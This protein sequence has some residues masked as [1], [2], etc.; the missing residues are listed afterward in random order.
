ME[1]ASFSWRVQGEWENDLIRGLL[2]TT[3]AHIMGESYLHCVA[4]NERLILT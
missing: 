1:T 4:C 3:I 2:V